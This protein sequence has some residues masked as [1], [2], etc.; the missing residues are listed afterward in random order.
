[1]TTWIEEELLKRDFYTEKEMRTKIQQHNE[2]LQQAQ[3]DPDALSYREKRRLKKDDQNMKQLCV[4][5][6]NCHKILRTDYLKNT[7]CCVKELCF[8][9]KKN[10]F[11]GRLEWEE[12][13]MNIETNEEVTARVNETLP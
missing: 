10:T 7:R 5:W 9:A 3:N 1:M 2:R 11:L 8:D 4:E 13:A 6:R 12:N